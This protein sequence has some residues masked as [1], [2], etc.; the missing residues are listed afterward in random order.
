MED[1]LP[2]VSLNSNTLE[3]EQSIL[4]TQYMYVCGGGVQVL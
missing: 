1:L 2:Q 3:A 4:S